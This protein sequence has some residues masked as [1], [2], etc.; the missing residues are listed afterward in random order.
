[1]Q[2]VAEFGMTYEDRLKS[3]AACMSTKKAGSPVGWLPF[4]Q[5]IEKTAPSKA[6]ADHILRQMNPYH[7]QI[8]FLSVHRCIYTIAQEVVRYGPDVAKRAIEIVADLPQF[9][10]W[11]DKLERAMT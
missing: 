9:K 8:L 1:M 5:H 6:A 7:R 10:R 4:V 11:E 3:F 2:L